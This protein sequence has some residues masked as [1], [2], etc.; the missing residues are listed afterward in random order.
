M[1]RKDQYKEEINNIVADLWQIANSA[2]GQMSAKPMYVLMYLLSGYKD[3]LFLSFEDRF[4]HH[5]F[6]FLQ[7]VKKVYE[8]VE[9][10]SDINPFY[11]DLIDQ[12]QPN[13]LEGIIMFLFRLERKLLNENFPKIFDSVLSSSNER[14]DVGLGVNFQPLELSRFIT[15]LAELSDDAKVYN[16]F[17]GLASFSTYLKS[18]Q[19]YIGQEIITSDWALGKLRLLAYG[20][21]NTRYVN[22]DSIKSWDFTNKYD[23]I[24]TR[25]PFQLK[26]SNLG[27]DFGKDSLSEF[28]IKNGLNSLSDKGKLIVIFPQSLLSNSITRDKDLRKN[29]VERNLIE[30]VITLPSRILS[31]AAVN[32]SIIILRKS[33]EYAAKI[34]M[35][36]ASSFIASSSHR[37][38][39]ILDDEKLWTYIN[40]NNNSEFVRFVEK[41]EIEREDFDLQVGRYFIDENISGTKL[42]E[43]ASFVAGKPFSPS[44]TLRATVGID[45]HRETSF[46]KFVR[47]KDLKND[48][49]N[50]NL[51]ITQLVDE[52]P[53][54][55]SFR[56]I[57]QN[58]LLIS[59]RF[60]T[61]KPTYFKYEGTPICISGDV[62]ALNIDESLYDIRYLIYALNSAQVTKQIE[63]YTAGQIMPRINKKDLLN[64]KIRIPSLDEQRNQYIELAQKQLST[65]SAQYGIDLQEQIIN[66]NDE[67]SFLRHQIAGSLKSVRNSF[68][69]V[70]KILSEKVNPEFPELY[71][72][73]VDYRLGST[74]NTY[75]N[76]I[77][78]D[79][80]S[81]NKSVNKISDQIDLMDLNLEE[82][83]LLKF[84]KDYAEDLRV[85]GHN[86]YDVFVDL[87][88]DSLIEGAVKNVYVKGDRDLLKKAFDNIVENAERHAFSKTINSGNKV[89]IDLLYDFQ[90]MKVQ[91]DF[92]NT[93]HLLPENLSYESMVRKGSSI[94]EN[95]GDG[96]GI[97]FVREVMK[98]HGGEFSFT[99]KKNGSEGIEGEYVT[100]IELTLPIIE[101]NE[102]L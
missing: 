67:N 5:D 8:S 41:S 49:F 20:N 22:E 13:I 10:Y 91:I 101:I 69:F 50:S 94:G 42:G 51:D 57:S 61:L 2:R 36:D 52:L 35:I 12:I 56:K 16:P 48:P 45:M 43:I 19:S 66:V 73:K 54:N 6:Y 44:G 63:K 14:S 27:N 53:S 76:I 79:L 32:L 39:N 62:Y 77:E 47:I 46:A 85:R 21:K 97:W 65:K 17:A 92:G 4:E 60:A 9:Q 29:L 23:L 31:Y 26:G 11:Q 24:V 75:L 74:L 100:T 7:E 1:I 82:F 3:G 88:E 59:S 28:I 70:Q 96:T 38:E 30:T 78:R 58:S 81:I 83:D 87:D 102:K 71:N 93:G 95:A 40:S 18:S 25:S 89:K 37:K 55:V 84:I 33:Q 34:R 64:L 90:D 68:K 80:N 98:I 86:Y 15:N 99:D 72:L